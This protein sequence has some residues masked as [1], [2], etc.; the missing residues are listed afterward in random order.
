M[1]LKKRSTEMTQLLNKSK[2]LKRI[3]ENQHTAES[4]EAF[5]IAERN[6]HKQYYKEN[7]QSEM[8]RAKQYGCQKITCS[9]G[10]VIQ[11]ASYP[12]HLK[13]NLHLSRLEQKTADKQDQQKDTEEQFLD[14]IHL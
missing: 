12:K 5:R 4:L 9:C 13:S 14:L 7:R 2:E 6:R 11:K 8:L 10:T 1:E 3:H